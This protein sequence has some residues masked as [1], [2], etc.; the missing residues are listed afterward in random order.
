MLWE[1]LYMDMAVSKVNSLQNIEQTRDI[2]M[3]ESS[4]AHVIG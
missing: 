2:S 1:D 3:T 4:T